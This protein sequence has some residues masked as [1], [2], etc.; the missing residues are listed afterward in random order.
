MRH[1]Y[2]TALMLFGFSLGQIGCVSQFDFG[3]DTPQN[4]TPEKT[5]AE[6]EIPAGFRFETTERLNI[7]VKVTE[8]ALNGNPDGLLKIQSAD[9]EVLFHGPVRKDV[10]NQISIRLPK[11]DS[12]TLDLFLDA[13][14]SDQQR[15]L[16]I[17]DFAPMT[18]VFNGRS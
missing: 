3:G 6:V 8:A 16:E 15:R 4:N 18:V 1:F 17:K 7:T 13:A 12:T 11:A 2:T 9:G 5:L 14:G 10:N